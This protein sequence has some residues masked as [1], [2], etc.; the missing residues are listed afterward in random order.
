MTTICLTPKVMHKKIVWRI[1]HPDGAHLVKSETLSL[2]TSINDFWP[3]VYRIES[4]SNS[5]AIKITSQQRTGWW[6]Q[7]TGNLFI[8]D[9]FLHRLKYSFINATAFASAFKYLQRFISP[10]LISAL[11]LHH[12]LPYEITMVVTSTSPPPA[13]LPRAAHSS[14]NCAQLSVVLTPNPI[15]QPS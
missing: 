1:R 9:T 3:I 4:S 5:N 7:P 14:A 15:K 13:C 11:F 8:T 10:P 2:R 12:S 6:A